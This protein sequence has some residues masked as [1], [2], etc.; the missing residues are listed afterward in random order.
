MFVF[1]LK[2]TTK[3][4]QAVSGIQNPEGAK[5]SR[6]QKNQPRMDTKG[7][8]LKR[9]QKTMRLAGT[10]TPPEGATASARRPGL[11]ELKRL[12]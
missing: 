1:F 4:R 3:G 9:H 7:R 10:L 12:D 2:N 11:C 5:G 6:N 8:E